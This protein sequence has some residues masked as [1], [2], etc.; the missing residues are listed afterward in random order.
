M[1]KA[2]PATY[3]Y[4]FVGD[5]PEDFPQPPIASRLNPGDELAL[6][7]PVEH[8]RLE[9]T[10]ATRKRLDAERKAAE[11]AR[12]DSSAATETTT[13]AADQTPASPA[14]E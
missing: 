7:T 4:I 5:T 6:P 14:K 3:D 13:T 11:A 2:D 1:P 8:A 9:P 10:P 12:D